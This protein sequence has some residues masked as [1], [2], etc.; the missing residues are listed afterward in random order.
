M[1]RRDGSTPF[2]SA[3]AARTYKDRRASVPVHISRDFGAIERSV[4]RNAERNA[5]TSQTPRRPTQA[6]THAIVEH[7]ANGAHQGCA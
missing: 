4:K 7:D 5:A 3:V 6:S 1:R 2:S